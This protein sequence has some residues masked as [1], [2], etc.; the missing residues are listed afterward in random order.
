LIGR[1]NL[2]GA[3]LQRETRLQS[4]ELFCNYYVPFAILLCI[5]YLYYNDD[6]TINSIVPT[7]EGITVPPVRQ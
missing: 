5:D 6:A 4:E 3:T 2:V 1:S 7:R